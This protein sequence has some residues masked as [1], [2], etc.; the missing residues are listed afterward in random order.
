MSLFDF[1]EKRYTVKTREGY[2][3]RLTAKQLYN[4]VIEDSEYDYNWIAS[5][6]ELVRVCNHSEFPDLYAEGIQIAILNCFANIVSKRNSPY[7]KPSD[8]DA[9]SHCY[10]ALFNI[11]NKASRIRRKYLRAVIECITRAYS[12]HS[13]LEYDKICDEWKRAK[14]KEYSEFSSL[15]FIQLKRTL[16]EDFENKIKSAKLEGILQEVE[17]DKFEGEFEDIFFESDIF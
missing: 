13:S 9:V 4:R 15:D 10:N 1:F 6:P 7:H 3:V 16:T 14:F 12:W 11:S 5:A 2:I 8:E 17:S